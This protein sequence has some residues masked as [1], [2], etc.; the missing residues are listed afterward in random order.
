MGKPK[1]NAFWEGVQTFGRKYGPNIAIGGGIAGLCFS[2]YT[3]ATE[4]PKYLEAIEEEK[5]KI[6][7]SGGEKLPPMTIV[8]TCWK[9]YAPTIIMS[10]L[11]VA[12]ILAGTSAN[13]RRSTALAAAY[14]LSETALSEYKD[15]VVETIGEKKEKVVREKVAEKQ[16]EKN[17]ESKSNV[18]VT[19]RGETL[20]Y[21]PLSGRYFKSD[22]EQLR[23]IENDLNY[24][25]IHHM[26]VSLNEVYVM[27]GLDTNELGAALGWNIDRCG[28]IK[29]DFDAKLTDKNEPCLVVDFSDMPVYDFERLE[30]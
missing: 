1:L 4:T 5:R 17:P 26:Y 24:R 7:I 3:A 23:K 14:K 12:C 20:C 27:L 13:Y 25:L 6:D 9:C 21:D 16:L 2:I 29:I 11:S 10:S 19:G 28:Y 18:F 22:V 15:A 8:K 30:Y